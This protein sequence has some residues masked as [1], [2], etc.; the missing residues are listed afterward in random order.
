[1]FQPARPAPGAVTL[2]GDLYRPRNTA[3][4][5]KLAHN[6]DGVMQYG[7]YL[8]SRIFLSN[9]VAPFMN[10]LMNWTHGAMANW[11]LAII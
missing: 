6:E 11:G 9:Y 3:G 7:R 1:V 8:Y 10:T 5:A 2:A 4:L